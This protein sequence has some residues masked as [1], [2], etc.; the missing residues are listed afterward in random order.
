MEQNNNNNNNNNNDIQS[1][2]LKIQTLQKEYE[3]TLQ[4]YQEAVRNY[5]NSLKSTDKIYVALH[6]RSWWGMGP[7]KEGSVAN[8]TE[9]ETM[10][11]NSDKC[12]GA[13]FN[14]VK[15]YCWTRTGDGDISTGETDNYALVPQQKSTLIAMR[16]LNYKLLKINK[17]KLKNNNNNNKNYTS[18][19]KVY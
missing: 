10:C 17:F 14:P 12:T 19:S 9:C 7:D 1:S 5:I 11:S 18:H 4:Q 15:R 16:N 3:V 6:G 2:Y 13:T 8:Q